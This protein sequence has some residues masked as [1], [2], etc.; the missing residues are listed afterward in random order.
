MGAQ[1]K[2]T[3]PAPIPAFGNADAVTQE[4]LKIYEYYIASDQ[5]EGR[6][7]PSRGYDAA[8]LYVASHL[9]EW[10]LKPGGSTTG[11]DGPLQPYFLP[12]E[13][14]ARTIV[15][16]ESKVTLTAPAPAGGGRGAGGPDGA[17]GGGAR[18]ARGARGGNGEPR[19][20][21]FDYQKEWTLAAA[22][23]RGAGT[24]PLDVSGNLVF[25]GNGYVVTKTNTNPYAG[26]D[27][28]GKI[29]VVA[30]LPA[31]VAAQQAAAGGRGGRGGGG[32]GNTPDPLG[33]ACTDYWTPEQYA[34][35]N[36]ALGVISVANFQQVA[37]MANP[38]AGGFGGGGGRGAGLNGPNYSIPK[39]QVAQ[40]CPALPAVTAGLELTTALF[41]GEK[42]SGAQVFYNTGANAKLDSFE[43]TS[44]KKL[45]IK[46]AVKTENNHGEDVIG[47][48]EGG[49]P[50]LKNEYVIIS[51]HLDHIGLATP[52][53]DGHTV[54]NGADDD[55]SGS[56]G[57]LA[58]A[59]IYAEGAAKGMRPKR[60]IIFLWNG[61]EEKG[62]WGSQYFAQY[63]TVDLSKVV[64]DLNMDMIGRTKTPTSVD[65]NA[66]HVLVDPGEVLMIGPNISS[67]D[68]GKTIDSVNADYQKLKINHFYD[69]TAPD[70]THDN[71]GPNPQGQRIF[72]RS[73]HYNFAKVGVPIAFFTTG[74][75]VDYHRPTDTPDKIDYKAMQQI[76][77]TVAAVGWQLANSPGRPKLNEKLPEQLLKDMK[78]AQEQGWGKMTPALPPLPGEPK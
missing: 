19:T 22:G 31:E 39:F 68:L 29:I 13:M 8:A 15:P 72:Y 27:V 65:N 44:A 18:G 62:L 56:C 37:A 10:G 67:D 43:L 21:T 34:A 77:R 38:N 64:A 32:R 30:G 23:G 25:A 14:V 33:V 42:L 20:T 2:K 59:R 26:I 5:M 55:G 53:P 75:H 78:T 7:F 3:K 73:D 1:Q 24:Q 35:K 54:N 69:V 4:E 40:S 11:T 9:A 6:N 51:A 17:A 49:D 66:Q 41:Q 63:P 74:L 12:I 76:T 61:G 58:M 60:S 48:L 16:D 36:G 46:V 57:L 52:Q 71:L 47:I 50:V 70:A 45:A 28:K